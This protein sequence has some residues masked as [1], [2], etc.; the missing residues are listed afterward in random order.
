MYNQTDA[1]AQKIIEFSHLFAVAGRQIVIHGNHVNPFSSKGIQIYRQRSH[2]RFP[3]P[4]LHLC[5]TPLMQNDAAHELHI[6][7]THSQHTIRSFPHNSIGLRQQI[8]QGFSF[9]QTLLKFNRLFLQLFIGKLRNR[10]GEAINF[11]HNFLQ[12]LYIF[13]RITVFN[14]SSQKF[15]SHVIDLLNIFASAFR[16]SF[17]YY[18]Q[19]ILYHNQSNLETIFQT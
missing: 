7:M 18:S 13:F 12:L 15:K 6:K 9:C 4:C 5:N 10:I 2:Q 19:F 8:I 3:F 17:S 16:Q 14:I 1:Q 11:R